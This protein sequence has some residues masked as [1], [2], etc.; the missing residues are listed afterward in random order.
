M[1]DATLPRA[2]AIFPRVE[3]GDLLAAWFAY[4]A[5][6]EAAPHLSAAT[7]RRRDA[8]ANAL[9]DLIFLAATDMT[10]ADVPPTINL[11]VHG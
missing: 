8:A 7:E 2:R 10:K 9:Y 1:R 11:A 5:K 4:D 3:T 6:L